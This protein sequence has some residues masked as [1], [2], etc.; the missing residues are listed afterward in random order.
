MV[1]IDR[2]AHQQPVRGVHVLAVHRGQVLGEQVPHLYLQLGGRLLCS[3]RRNAFEICRVPDQAAR[4]VAMMCNSFMRPTLPANPC[5]V[6]FP[7]VESRKAPAAQPPW[8][9]LISRRRYPIKRFLS[10]PGVY[11]KGAGANRICWKKCTGSISQKVP[12]SYF[13]SS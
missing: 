11:I 4:G 3:C 9:C 2:P 8:L 5:S 1:R 6:E 10:S 7:G 12:A 13:P